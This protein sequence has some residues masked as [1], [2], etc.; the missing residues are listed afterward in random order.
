MARVCPG[1]ALGEQVLFLNISRLLALFD[2]TY[3]CDALGRKIEP[4]QEM[5]RGGIMYVFRGPP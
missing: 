1:K 3:A 4:R 2:F 5:T